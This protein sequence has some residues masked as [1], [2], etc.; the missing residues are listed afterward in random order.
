MS[1][2]ISA[3]DIVINYEWTCPECGYYNCAS[4]INDVE[5]KKGNTLYCD[6]CS[7]ECEIVK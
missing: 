7:K 6:E 5:P 3:G 4:A 1:N 2:T